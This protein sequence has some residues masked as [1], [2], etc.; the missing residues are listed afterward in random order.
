MLLKNTLEKCNPVCF[1]S[2]E[3]FLLRITIQKE[4]LLTYKH[5]MS[6]PKLCILCAQNYLI[7]GFIY[8]CSLMGKNTHIK[9]DNEKQHNA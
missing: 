7:L 2:Q 3:A 6:T 8:L 5:K 9:Y 1:L 4:L